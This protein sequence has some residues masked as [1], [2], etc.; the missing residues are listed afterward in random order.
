MNNSVLTSIGVAQLQ[1]VFTKAQDWTEEQYDIDDLAVKLPQH[2]LNYTSIA[3]EGAALKLAIRGLR[4][5]ESL[6]EWRS[7][8]EDKRNPSPVASYLGLG[9]ALAQLRLDPSP[10]VAEDL[11][12]LSNHIWEG[13][14]YYND[15]VRKRAVT[16]YLNDQ[17]NIAKLSYWQG[18]GR[19]C[20]YKS[21]GDLMLLKKLSNIV[22]E[23]FLKA[24][25]R[26]VGIGVVY[27]G[28]GNT[29]FWDEISELAGPYRK[30]LAVAAIMISHSL[31]ATKRNISNDVFYLWCNCSLEKA[32][33]LYQQT[34]NQAI[35]EE[36][37][38]IPFLRWLELIEMQL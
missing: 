27:L 12:W 14:G 34:K 3:F 22:E 9:M 4:S 1:Y 10:Y 26:G 15:F 36:A 37:Y 24:F 17:T 33:E 35:N 2:F 20:W 18:V 31:Q 23:Q 30:S 25:W 6:V 8:A 38:E 13:Y 7:L 19:S 32:Q 5:Q 28:I 29:S 21:E 11:N 16:D